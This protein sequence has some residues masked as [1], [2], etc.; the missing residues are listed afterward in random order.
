MP[1]AGRFFMKYT[2]PLVLLSVAIA[3]VASACGGGGKGGL[4]NGV[5]ATVKGEKITKAQL[6]AVLDQAR[7]S[8]KA[9]KRTFPKAGTSDYQAIVQSAV[10]FLVK[11]TEYDQKAKE[12][13]VKV[14]A[15]DVEK[16][17]KEIKK[18]YFGGSEKKYQAAL[19]KQ[20]L[21]DKEVRDSIRANLVQEGIAAKVTKGITVSEDEVHAYYLQHPQQYSTPESRLVAHI[22]VKQQTLANKVYKELCGTASP[23][24][25]SKADFAAAAKKYSIDTGTKTQGGKYNAVRGASVPEFDKV[26]FALE[27]GEISKPVHTRFGWHVIK[28]LENTKPRKTTPYKQVKEAIRQQLLSQKKNDAL[29]KFT[30]DLDK[31][32]ANQVKYAQGYEPPTTSTA[33]TTTASTTG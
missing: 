9:Q 11:R 17:L 21:T 6:D 33:G 25:K 15:A 16:R 28:A 4:P 13:G 23:C 20:G 5:V 1:A 27:T 32:Y 22:L 10:Q 14:T 29:T 26:A 18:Q 7:R 3:L 30:A 12:L 8:Y 2:R 24:L 31:E 19:K